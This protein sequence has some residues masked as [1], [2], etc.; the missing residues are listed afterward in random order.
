MACLLCCLPPL[1]LACFS[2]PLPR[3]GRIAPCPPSP[4]GKGEIFS[5]LMQGAS[6]LASPRLSRK[7]HGL[8]LRNKCPMG[9]LPFWL[10]AYPAFSLL[11]CP[12]SP[13]G[14]DSPPPPF[15]DGEGGVFWF[16]PPGAPPPAPRALDRLRHL[17]TLPN[18]CPAE[19]LPFWLLAYPAFRF[20][21]CPI[22]PPPSRREGGNQGYF[23][24][25]AS[26]L[27]F[28]RLSRKRHGLN[29]QNKYPMGGL[30]FWLPAYSAFSLFFCPPS[31]K[32]KDSPPP[33]FPDGE[34][35]VFWFIP[36]GAPPPAPRALD[37]LRHL[38]TLPNRYP[39]VD[40]GRYHSQGT[41]SCRF[42][43]NHGLSPRDARG[44]A[45]CIRKL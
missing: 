29:L 2:A 23:M 21:F 1:P 25:G 11:F 22:P 7:R 24:Q 39:A 13:K 44:E 35:G 40:S 42:A 27:A 10:P 15:P 14:K 20:L 36:P 9:G 18:R 4:P 41:A 12:P 6:P 8:N 32:G 17:Q 3:R 38:Q 37:R 30:P 43:V 45:P 33:P 26:P 28:P 16:I 5:F 31:P 34:G 19:G